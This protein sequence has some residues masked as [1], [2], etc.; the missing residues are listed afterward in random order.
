MKKLY[1]ILLLISTI[2]VG[3]ILPTDG[4]S[5]YYSSKYCDSAT[6]VEEALTSFYW[7]MANFQDCINPSE[8]MLNAIFGN[9]QIFDSY[10][11]C[12]KVAS[13]PGMPGSYTN[14]PGS[15]CEEYLNEIE[16]LSIQENV[17]EIDG[18]YYDI[19]GRRYKTIPR[20][21]SFMNY[22]KYFKLN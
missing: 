8:S 4:D 17:K 13:T 19:Y 5:I 21:I 15:A 3:Q 7:N 6:S 20:G 11:C 10:E 12:C 16:F 22:K 14:F 9:L 1:Y 18:M 2:S